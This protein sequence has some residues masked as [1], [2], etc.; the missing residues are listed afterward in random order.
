MTGFPKSRIL[1]AQEKA[2]SEIKR[3]LSG[4]DDLEQMATDAVKKL[5]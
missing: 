1:I 3:H 5:S 2:A 4:P